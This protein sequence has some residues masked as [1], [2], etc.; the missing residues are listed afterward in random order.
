M[1]NKYVL[2]LIRYERKWNIADEE[3]DPENDYMEAHNKFCSEPF[4]DQNNDNQFSN[5]QRRNV[6]NENNYSRGQHDG[7]NFNNDYVG[8]SNQT[9]GSQMMRN[10][11][12]DYS[13][14]NSQI[15]RNNQ[16]YSH[17]VQTLKNTEDNYYKHQ[18]N[19]RNMDQRF[20]KEASL[21]NDH[22]DE[23]YSNEH[24]IDANN[25]ISK[26][27]DYGPSSR[28]NFKS[29][30]GNYEPFRGNYGPS[31]GN[32][33]SSRGN[34]GNRDSFKSNF[35]N[36]N[37]NKTNMDWDENYKED[38]EPRQP[39][40]ETIDLPP[41]IKRPYE[42]PPIDP[43]KIFDYRHLP[44]LKVIPGNLTFKLINH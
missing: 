21:S 1:F 15:S 12:N 5:T 24:I 11:E 19:V 33:G 27:G 41:V 39:P 10:T 35:G 23:E 18:N 34:G 30:R 20:P 37:T 40:E 16:N 8:P 22:I 14:P 2:L 6:F 31:R 36:N 42:A 38:E 29:S 25:L 13:R 4:D 44:T 3:D 26:R 7:R 9:R 43:I 28:G 17:D 32:Y